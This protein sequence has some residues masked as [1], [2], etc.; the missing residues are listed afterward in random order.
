[1]AEAS[2]G[3]SRARQGF[4]ISLVVAVVGGLAVAWLAP[5]LQGPDL[6]VGWHS[7]RDT[8]TL[9]VYNVGDRSAVGCV[10]HWDLAYQNGLSIVSLRSAEFHVPAGDVASPAPTLTFRNEDGP[11]RGE[12]PMLT[13]TKYVICIDY[14]S[15]DFKETLPW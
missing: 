10:G 1:V 8:I 13:L 4:V 7:Y 15:P 14:R 2:A 5:K 11:P 3:H 9:E 6:R 12:H